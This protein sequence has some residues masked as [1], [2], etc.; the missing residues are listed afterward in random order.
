MA[1]GQYDRRRMR[2][3][4]ESRRP[5]TDKKTW[6]TRGKLPHVTQMFAQPFPF[7]PYPV[8][9]EYIWQHTAHHTPTGGKPWRRLSSKPAAKSLPFSK[10]VA[11][12]SPT[13]STITPSPP[14]LT[15][16]ATGF[17]T[18]SPSQE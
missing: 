9:K 11:T 13:S 7:L 17:S 1:Y 4:R 14:P 12:E 10:R 5:G 8:Y 16:R 2:A 18:A 15:P 3:A 6:Q